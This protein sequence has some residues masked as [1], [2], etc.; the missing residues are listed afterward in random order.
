MNLYNSRLYMDD[1]D[2]VIQ[3]NTWMQR[4]SGKAIFVTGAAGL[5]CSGVVDLLLR[6]N[7]LH[8]AGI[9]IY[10]AGRNKER[11][12]KRF[13][14]YSDSG[15]LEYVD[16][17]MGKRNKFPEKIDYIV[18]GAGNAFPEIIQKKPIDTINGA[19]V[20]T[21]ALLDYAVANPACKIVFISSSEVYGNK[22]TTEPFR[23]EEYGGTNILSPRS[24]YAV[25]KMAAETLCISYVYEKSCTVSIVRPG[26]IYGP[27][28]GRK[29]N[30]IS[31]AFAYAAAE[32][33]D[34]ILKSN[35]S[36]IRSYCY[37]LDCATA[38]L[39]VTLDGKKAEAYNISNPQSIISIKEISGLF[40][41]C[42]KCRLR[43]EI[44]KEKERQAFN[45]MQNSS[46]NSDRLQMLEWKG[47]F[48]AQKGAFHTVQILREGMEIW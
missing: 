45:P 16:Y 47:L 46:L 1:L 24:S 40:A 19:F 28:A 33:R 29:D 21:K 15:W 3:K 44:P 34:L 23:E 26:H 7:E 43:F 2:Y 25:G 42:G 38:I 32:G 5:I 22:E 48:D 37:V 13:L 14:K 35:G 10:A 41:E 27:T 31:S 4:L 8:H 17:D 9:R 36:Q 12:E 11:M 18:H 6:Y 39:K 20:S 30:R